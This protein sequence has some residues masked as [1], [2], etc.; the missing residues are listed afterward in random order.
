VTEYVAV[1]AVTSLGTFIERSR[2]EFWPLMGGS[3]K[4]DMEVTLN[5]ERP[6]EQSDTLEKTCLAKKSARSLNIIYS[7]TIGFI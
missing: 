6:L 7:W 5:W 2:V 3:G 4:K 1:P